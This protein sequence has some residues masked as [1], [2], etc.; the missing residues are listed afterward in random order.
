MKTFAVLEPLTGVAEG[1]DARLHFLDGDCLWSVTMAGWRP[2]WDRFLPEG[3]RVTEG[4]SGRIAIGRFSLGKLKAWVV[5][6]QQGEAAP[7]ATAILESLS[8]HQRPIPDLFF[9]MERKLPASQPAIMGIVNVTPDSFSDGGR[10]NDPAE[11]VAHGEALVDAG[12][13]ILDV[14]GE[15]TRPGAEP[16]PEAEELARVIPVIKGLKKRV[17]VPLSIDTSKAA[18][19]QA[20]LAAGVEMVNDVTALDGDPASLKFMAREAACPVTIM[21]MQG[22]P[23]DMQEAPSY[24]NVLVDVYRFLS[25]RAEACVQAGIDRSRLVIDPGIGFGKSGEHNLTLLRGLR[26]FRGLGLPI[27]LGVSRKRLIGELTGE[28]DPAQR[29]VGSHILAAWGRLRGASVLR[30]HDVAGARQALAVACGL[31]DGLEMN[32]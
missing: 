16:V 27:L 23:R 26:S 3:F 13:H 24:G 22:T 30:V 29:D 18:V 17:D 31:A 19:M 12:A 2:E 14:G 7:A 15:S 20:A 21:H 6:L 25:E 28:G 32:R 8:A 9:G 5:N 10:F 11:A 4:A 1:G